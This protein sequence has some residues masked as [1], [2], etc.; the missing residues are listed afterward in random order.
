MSLNV[1]LSQSNI[2]SLSQRLNRNVKNEMFNYVEAYGLLPTL[3]QNNDAFIIISNNKLVKLKKEAD[4]KYPKVFN[5][6]KNRTKYELGSLD[7][8]YYDNQ[9]RTNDNFRYK[10]RIQNWR[11]HLGKRHYDKDYTDG[12]D[13]YGTERASLDQSPRNRYGSIIK[14]NKYKSS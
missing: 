1:F 11:A 4:K 10:N 8:M 3:K 13:I 12:F 6:P 14:E 7:A 2:D 9:Y 5:F